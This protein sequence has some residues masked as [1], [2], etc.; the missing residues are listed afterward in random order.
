MLSRHADGLFWL[1]RYV[2]RAVDVNRLLDV[3]YNAQLERSADEGAEVWRD[4]LRV[5]SKQDD[6][7]EKHGA[8]L[9]TEK[10]N[11]FLVFDAAQPGSVA[12]SVRQART[13][14]M[15]VRDAVPIEMLESVNA[16]HTLLASRA[17]EAIADSS[18]HEIYDAVAVGCRRI[19]GVIEDGMA[20]DDAYSFLMLGRTLERAEM[21][22]RV[23]EVS[24][25]VGRDDAA[26][27][28]G[29]LRSLSGMHSFLRTHGPLASAGDVADYLLH[30]EVFPYGVL[31]CLRSAAEHLASVTE[32]GQWQSPRALGRVASQVEFMDVPRVDSAQFE[33]VMDEVL[34]GIRR[35]A[36]TFTE[37]LYRFGREP[38]LFSF[39]AM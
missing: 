29:A 38:S 21:T 31:H 32:A 13:N 8:G 23:I 14:V 34:V 4:L 2:G 22:C 16:L 9:S 7:S 37:D 26:T 3:A 27:W 28:M 24:A 10:L 11:R 39:E 18:P 20:R 17:L 1:G 5:L 25:S 36:N 15:N 33:S 30:S 6:F 12:H 35:V 19:A